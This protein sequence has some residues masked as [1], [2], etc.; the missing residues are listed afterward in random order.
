M[1]HKEFSEKGGQ[2]KSA[3]KIKAARK[4]A[5]KAREALAKKRADKMEANS[6]D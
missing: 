3:K 2:S 1:T 6:H 4:N 5:A